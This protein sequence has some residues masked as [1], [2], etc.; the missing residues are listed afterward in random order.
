MSLIWKF[1]FGVGEIRKVFIFT[2]GGMGI[3]YGHIT[4]NIGLLQYLRWFDLPVTLFVRGENIKEIFF[5][6]EDFIRCEWLSGFDEKN[7]DS[8]TLVF[9]DSYFV[10]DKFYKKIFDKTEKL[11]IYDDFKRLNYKVGY[12]LN[13]VAE[14]GF[15]DDYDKVLR[16]ESF[17]FLRRAFWNTE[18]RSRK[19][20]FKN[21][22]VTLGGNPSEELLKSIVEEIKKRYY[23]LTIKVVSD[24][25]EGIDA[26]FTGYCSSRDMVKLMNWADVAISAG[27][28]TLHE[29]FWMKVPTYMLKLAENQE[30]NIRYYE[31][32]GFVRILD[33]KELVVCFN[34]LEFFAYEC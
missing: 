33:L 22:L 18:I 32:R 21:V 12:I 17:I 34:K 25:V 29:L 8:K 28:Q 30:Y 7:I 11:V 6:G 23:N 16:G 13:P 31:K 15:Y 24:V 9:V 19:N 10:N 5:E 26:E 27:G 1:P 20:D 4:R 14:D 2:E 3:G